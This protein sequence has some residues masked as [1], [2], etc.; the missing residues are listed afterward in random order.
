MPLRTLP[1]VCKPEDITD[2]DFLKTVF[3]TGIDALNKQLAEMVQK[4]AQ[5]NQEELAASG[6]TVIEGR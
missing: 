1:E 3:I 4:Y 6:I 5:E 2:A